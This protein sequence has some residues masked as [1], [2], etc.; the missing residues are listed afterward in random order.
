MKYPDRL[1]SLANRWGLAYARWICRREY[2]SQIYTGFNERAVE[3]LFLFRQLARYWPKTVLDV[4][5]GTTSLPHLIRNCGFL[6][7]A[8]DNIGDYWNYGIV[9]RHYHVLNDDI[10]DSRLGASFDFITCI[11]VLEHIEN[12]GAALRNIFRLLNPGGHAVLTFPY[13]EKKYVRNVYDL[14]GSDARVKYPFITQVFS[15]NELDAW[16]TE[17]DGTLIEQEYWRFY[18]GDYWTIGNMIDRPVRVDRNEPHH[19]SCVLIQKSG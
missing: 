16:L 19:V 5:T 4:G 12:H 11:S 15:R 1:V 17:N 2:R 18:T 7:T 3:L 10:T 8:I 13:N 9:N 14:P 6:V